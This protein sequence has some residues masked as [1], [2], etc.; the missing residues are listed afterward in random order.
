M[1]LRGCYTSG[2]APEEVRGESCDGY[3]V[4]APT[5][6]VTTVQESSVWPPDDP[7]NFP[8]VASIDEGRAP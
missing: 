3:Q 6:Q 4:K 7:P 8:G 5:P 1:S 2:P